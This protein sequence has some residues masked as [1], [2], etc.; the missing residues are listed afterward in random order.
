MMPTT[1]KWPIPFRI[2]FYNAE[3]ILPSQVSAAGGR[4]AVR[5]GGD[6]L[7]V[8]PSYAAFREMVSEGILWRFEFRE[9]T[10]TVPLPRLKVSLF[11]PP[12][13]GE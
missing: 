3:G 11:P 9:G 1:R 6:M 2:Y 8:W 4:I 13:K 12:L 10:E 7:S 5:S